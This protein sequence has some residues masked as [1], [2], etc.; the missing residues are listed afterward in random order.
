MENR[1][2][3]ILFS[4]CGKYPDLY[5]YN[6]VWLF[7]GFHCTYSICGLHGCSSFETVAIFARLSH[8]CRAARLHH[9][10]RNNSPEAHQKVQLRLKYTV[11]LLTFVS[12]LKSELSLALISNSFSLWRFR[13]RMR[14]L[15]IRQCA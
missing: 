2:F 4:E 5:N 14:C 6:S 1:F 3:T 13:R 8:Y 15:A 12:H 10:D 9:P 7:M 11:I